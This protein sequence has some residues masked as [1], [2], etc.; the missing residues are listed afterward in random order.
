I[1]Q[2]EAF[3]RA[4]L[5]TVTATHETAATFMAQ[6]YFRASGRLAVVSAIPGPGFAYALPALAEARLDS[7][8]LVLLTGRPRA[9]ADGRRRAQAIDQSA[10]ARPIVKDVVDV[11]T[12]A[13][14]GGAVLRAC[15]LAMTGEPGPVLVQ[16]SVN[17]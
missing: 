3:R 17:L 5:R 9:S 16:C 11:E 1:A 13:Q 4:G 10:M 2:Y 6:G 12:A 8:G 7:A 14:V 15:H